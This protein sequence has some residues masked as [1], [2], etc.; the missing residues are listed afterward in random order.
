MIA[1]GLI[2][3]SILGPWYSYTLRDGPNS[4]GVTF[5]SSTEQGLFGEYR[6]R[7][8]NDWR[9]F[10]NWSDV[11]GRNNQ[12][13]LYSHLFS[14]ELIAVVLA[15]GMVGGIALHMRKGKRGVAAAFTV[16]TVIWCV[17]MPMFFMLN[18]E[19]AND[20]DSR[21]GGVGSFW[22]ER[23]D[24]DSE[25][26]APGNIHHRISTWGPGTGWFLSILAA[27]SAVVT[28]PVLLYTG[29]RPGF[30]DLRIPVAA[31]MVGIICLVGAAILLYPQPPPW[32]QPDSDS[33]STRTQAVQGGDWLV[34]ITGGSFRA[35]GLELV[36]I[37]STTGARTMQ[38]RVPA[39]NADNPDF[40][41]NDSN[42]NHRLDAGDS[43]LLKG[44]VNG[45]PNPNIL[46]GFKA[47]FLKNDILVATIRELPP[48]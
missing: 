28:L 21:E 24:P 22:G 11:D 27:I 29:P 9:Q 3:G 30:A 13:R 7:S 35:S 6:F 2:I 39:G 17:F 15:A 23:D 4:S 33:M 5:T 18:L 12:A 42:R 20:A 38:A 14:L 16:A 31:G 43:I 48:H 41:W 34:E 8:E 37:N 25:I 26:G 19:P 46:A 47:Q 36:V 32:E 1:F 10:S 45:Q 40:F 44:T